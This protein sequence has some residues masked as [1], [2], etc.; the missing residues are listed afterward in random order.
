M[1][2]PHQRY[3][4]NRNAKLICVNHAKKN[5]TAA[6]AKGAPMKALKLSAPF[7]F[8]EVVALG[9]EEPV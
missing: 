7:G 5:A 6:N 8:A 4:Y 9:D 2:I 1:T 3:I